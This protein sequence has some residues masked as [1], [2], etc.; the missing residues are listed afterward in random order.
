MR[1]VCRTRFESV[2]LQLVPGSSAATGFGRSAPEG[3]HICVECQSR[4]VH[5]IDWEGSTD[6]R[7]LVTLRCPDCEWTG[8]GTF[9]DRVVEALERELDRGDAELAAEAALLTE[10]NMTDFVA[11]FAHALDTDAIQPMDF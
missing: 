7:R 1:R 6:D 5:P 9:D 2:A 3:L 4:L 10:A 11:R 8:L